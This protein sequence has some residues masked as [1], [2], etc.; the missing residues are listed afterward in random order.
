MLLCA[1]KVAAANIVFWV[2][3]TCAL[4]DA[5]DRGGRWRI[6]RAGC[7]GFAV[8]FE[9][10]MR[11]GARVL[12][13]GTAPELHGLRG[14]GALRCPVDATRFDQGLRRTILTLLALDMLEPRDVYLDTVCC[15]DRSLRNMTTAFAFG[16]G[17][18]VSSFF[19][20]FLSAMARGC[21]GPFSSQAA[22]LADTAT[23]SSPWTMWAIAWKLLLM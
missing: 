2:C 16:L 12:D 15:W 20:S 6:W 13:S 23:A 5:C 4:S 11:F 22:Q 3:L 18:S 7:G 9:A 8:R 19:S 10:V 1:F 21:W 17:A 14:R